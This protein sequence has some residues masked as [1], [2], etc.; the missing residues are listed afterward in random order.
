[1]KIFV[2]GATHSNTDN[3]SQILVAKQVSV[4]GLLLGLCISCAAQNVPSRCSVTINQGD[5][6][7]LKVLTNS[8]KGDKCPATTFYSDKSPESITQVQALRKAHGFLRMVIQRETGD[9]VCAGEAEDGVLNGSYT[10]DAR[11]GWAK[12]LSIRLIPEPNSIQLEEYAFLNVTKAWILALSA[13]GIKD[14]NTDNISQLKA[15]GI[16][17]EYVDE[18]RS[19]GMTQLNAESLIELKSIKETGSEIEAYADVLGETPSARDLLML[20]AMKVPPSDLKKFRPVNGK[21]IS[22]SEIIAQIAIRTVK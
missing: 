22:V 20:H 11:E 8:C 9:L 2:A 17:S 3:H 15:L 6:L 21:P 4:V 1:M 12:S 10:F 5:N 13:S 16:A 18:L 7:S 19:A 14:I